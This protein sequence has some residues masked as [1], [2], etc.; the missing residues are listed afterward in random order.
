MELRTKI[1]IGIT[2]TWFAIV[3]FLIFRD[4]SALITMTLNE[5]GDFLA[6]VTAPVALFWLVIGYFQQGEELRQ[7]TTALESQQ[8]ELRRQ[9][10]ETAILAK[11][12]ERQARAAEQLAESTDSTAE[13]QRRHT[14]AEAQPIFEAKGG[15]VV[16]NRTTTTIINSGGEARNVKLEYDGK[17]IMNL[18]APTFWAKNSTANLQL[19]SFDESRIQFPICFTLKYKDRFDELR[20]KFF[21][22]MGSGHLVEIGDDDNSTA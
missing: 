9:V 16:Q 6:G 8:E 18:K 2:T 5:L 13:R 22:T 1:A 20:T 3:G 4:F 19:S 10:E 14:I 15:S 7:N 17:Y 11:N 12:A 21:K